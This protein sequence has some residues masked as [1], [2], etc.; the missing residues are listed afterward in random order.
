[1]SIPVRFSLEQYQGNGKFVLSPAVRI[2]YYDQEMA[3]TRLQMVSQ[4]PNVS[5]TYSTN[6]F[7]FVTGAGTSNNVTLAA[8][9]Y[10]TSDI[11]AALAPNLG[12]GSYVVSPLTGMATLTINVDTSGK[13]PQLTIS[14]SL[15]A[16]LGLPAGTYPPS[17]QTTTYTITGSQLPQNPVAYVQIHTQMTN[18]DPINFF[19]QSIACFLLNQTTNAS[20][21]PTGM[22]NTLYQP[23]HPLF[24]PIASDN[25][26]RIELLFFDQNMNPLPVG[27]NV[28]IDVMIRPKK[29]GPDFVPSVF[30]F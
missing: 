13:T 14:P 6:V 12:P 1:M 8:G 4:I 21:Q 20:N 26:A 28:V 2:T 17:A 25:Y 29:A 9:Y 24:F 18:S 10:Q 5:A 19:T 11:N 15:G 16:L 3:I 22:T 7:P 23:T 30:P 27:P